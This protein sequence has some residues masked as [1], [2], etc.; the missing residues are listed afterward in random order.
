VQDV[1]V[2][3]ERRA[4]DIGDADP[5]AG[6]DDFF[7]LEHPRLLAMALALTGVREVAVDIAQEAMVRALRDWERVR[8]LD[9]P[10]G[11]VRR[12]ATNLVNDWHRGNARFARYAPRLV[13]DRP[14]LMADPESARFWAAVRAL[15]DVQRSV[16]A[17]YYLEDRSV[18]E[19]AELLE[20]P[21]GTVKSSLSRARSALATVLGVS[22]DAPRSLR[23]PGTDDVSEWAP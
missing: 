17:L 20:V 3:P 21:T 11:W 23:D 18:A 1:L 2:R 4:E 6:F 13:D 5:D 16:I 10:A 14:T 19:V 12:V 22:D 9:S 15:P 7:R 8:S